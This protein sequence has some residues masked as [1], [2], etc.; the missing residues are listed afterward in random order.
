[1]FETVGKEVVFLKRIKIG[2]LTLHGLDR[3]ECRKLSLEEIEYLK[4]V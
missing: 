1:M 2:E 3:G 4:N